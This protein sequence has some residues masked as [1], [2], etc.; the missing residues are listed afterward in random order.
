MNPLI[1]D[2]DEVAS[3]TI[4]LKPK[5]KDNFIYVV[6]LGDL[7]VG[8][9]DFSGEYLQ[10]AIS[11][12]ERLAKKH[13]VAIVLMG[14]LIE[15]EGDWQ[16]S[17]MIDDTTLRLKAQIETVLSYLNPVKD[18]VVTC[19]WGNHE[20]R[21]VRDNK[22]K[23]IFDALE[24]NPLKIMVDKLNGNVILGEPQRGL[25]LNIKTG[26]KEYGIRLLHGKYGGYK[27]PE[28]Q[29]EREGMGYPTVSL[30][31]MGHT[32]QKLW[33]EKIMFIPE[34][35]K[36]A[37]AIQY[38][39]NTGT[40]LRNPAYAEAKSYSPNVM[41]VPIVKLYDNVEH[42]EFVNSPELTPRFVRTAGMLPLT[43]VKIK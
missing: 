32:H 41:S 31:A 25:T 38:W 22:T 16:S 15:T 27:R 24:I 10:K 4:D 21:L 28:L 34:D 33:R 17:Y 18:L 40:C 43:P 23:K 37:I 30:I 13:T 42:I 7:H 19:I 20:E 8:H 6:F 36:R 29:F 1:L 39:L 5:G 11:I 9:K 35:G 3:G 12:V 2:Y 14:D 26:N